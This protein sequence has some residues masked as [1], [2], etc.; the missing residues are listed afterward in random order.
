MASKGRAIIKK[1]FLPML[2]LA[3]CPGPSLSHPSTTWGCGQLWCL[4]GSCPQTVVA[5]AARVQ[6]MLHRA[7]TIPEELSATAPPRVLGV[8]TPPRW[9]PVRLLRGG[10]LPCLYRL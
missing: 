1:L 8:S 10:F 3:P 4:P 7:V 6:V 9:G 5:L 2:S